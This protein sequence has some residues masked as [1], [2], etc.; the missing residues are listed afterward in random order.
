MDCILRKK[1][2]ERIPCSL[3]HLT[4]LIVMLGGRYLEPEC[5]LTT[6]YREWDVLSLIPDHSGI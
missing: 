6:Y 3:S 4:D 1:Y 2:V 5:Y